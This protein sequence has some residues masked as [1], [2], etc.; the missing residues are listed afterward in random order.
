MNGQLAELYNRLKAGIVGQPEVLIDMDGLH[1]NYKMIRQLTQEAPA[2]LVAKMEQTGH[3]IT[4]GAFVIVKVVLLDHLRLQ[5]MRAE[6]CPYLEWAG[7]KVEATMISEDVAV[8]MLT[9]A[10]YTAEDIQRR[11]IEEVTD[12]V[13][14]E[15]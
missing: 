8:Q 11:W 15:L 10:G 2:E 14:I 5:L 9:R 4:L 6:N 7:A 1:E 13:A 3:P 12:I